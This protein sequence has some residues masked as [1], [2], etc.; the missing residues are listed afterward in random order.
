MAVAAPAEAAPDRRSAPARSRTARRPGR[1]APE[2]GGDPWTDLELALAA[3]GEARSLTWPAPIV[4]LGPGEEPWSLLAA[5]QPIPAFPRHQVIR[6][7][8]PLRRVGGALAGAVSRLRGGGVRTV[9]STVALLV[10]VGVAVVTTDF[11]GHPLVHTSGPAEASVSQGVTLAGLRV[12][13][14]ASEAAAANSPAQSAFTSP[15]NSVVV[16]GTLGGV[17]E[18]TSIEFKVQRLAGPGETD[19]TPVA[20]GS[21]A[22]GS[23]GIAQVGFTIHAAGGPLR[24]GTYQVD[25]LHG[26]RDLGVVQ[27][28]VSAG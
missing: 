23:S 3:A 15:V 24:P 17:T 6:R 10:A 16:T 25:V 8:R 9:I 5:A 12:T 26:A 28:T 13:Q 18:G 2:T 4:P 19:G 22:L 27:F 14:A 11:F 7:R 1:S 21:R 20:D